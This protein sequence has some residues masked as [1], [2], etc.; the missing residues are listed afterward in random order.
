MPEDSDSSRSDDGT[1]QKQL[2]DD[3]LIHY[4]ET[5][6]RPFHSAIEVANEFSIDRSTAYRRLS[7]LQQNGELEKHF[8]GEKNT[9]W[10]RP[11][12]KIVLTEEDGSIVA[13]DTTLEIASQGTTRAGALEMIADAIRL[14]EQ[15]EDEKEVPEPDAPWFDE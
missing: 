10:W 8:V 7:G 15:T 4:F 6:D 13:H 5:S 2:Q 1:F 12:D 3:E 11:R 14:Y 9:I